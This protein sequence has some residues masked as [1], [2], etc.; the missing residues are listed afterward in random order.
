MDNEEDQAKEA[1]AHS[2]SDSTC[3]RIIV[4]DTKI[5]KERIYFS[6]RFVE[7][8]RQGRMAEDIQ[9]LAGQQKV[10][11]LPSLSPLIFHLGNKLI[12]HPGRG[13]HSPHPAPC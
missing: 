5:K 7:V 11:S 4:P 1:W 10:A 2:K 3:S 6:P 9:S 8:S 12:D 13:F